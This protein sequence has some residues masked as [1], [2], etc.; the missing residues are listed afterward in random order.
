MKMKSKLLDKKELRNIPEEFLDRIL[1]DAKKENSKLY[2]KLE[3]KQFNEKSKEFKEFKKIVRKKLRVL[4]GVFQKETLSKEKKEKYLKNIKEGT[5]EEKE[6]AIQKILKSHLSTKE[7]LNHFYKVYS[8]IVEICGKPKKIADLACGFNPF[9]YYYWNSNPEYFA[10]DISKEDMKFIQTFFDQNKI[11]GITLAGDLTKESFQNKIIQKIKD[12]DTCLLF[13]AFDSLESLNKGSSS[14]LISKIP[15]K[16]IIISFP[17]KTISGKNLITGKRHWFIQALKQ[18][19]SEGWNIHEFEIGY[20][21][22][23]F[24][25]KP[26]RLL[27]TNS[28]KS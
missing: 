22:Y 25:T 10:T 14:K 21:I 12:F 15:C 18:K 8:K 3:E 19:N 7:R 9:S 13:K 6:K 24:L 2:S 4:Y 16:I 17:S 20:E 5:V 23:Y 11:K 26:Q 28:K 27:S 1:E